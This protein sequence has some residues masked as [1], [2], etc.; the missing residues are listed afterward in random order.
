MKMQRRFKNMNIFEHGAGVLDASIGQAEFG[1]PVVVGSLVHNSGRR[2]CRPKMRKPSRLRTR[3]PRR[4]RRPMRN[5]LRS[6]CSGW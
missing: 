3:K 5:R 2:T 1:F 4:Q 6:S